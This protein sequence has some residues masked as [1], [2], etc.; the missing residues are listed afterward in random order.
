MPHPVCLYVSPLLA[1]YGFP[2]GH[3]FGID[4]QGAFWREAQKQGLDK[5]IS[6]AYPVSAQAYYL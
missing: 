2:K 1:R 4:R 6:R 3:P 5:R